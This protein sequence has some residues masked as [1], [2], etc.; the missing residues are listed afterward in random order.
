MVDLGRLWRTSLAVG[1]AGISESLIS[2]YEP[3][4]D[5]QGREGREEMHQRLCRRSERSSAGTLANARA[6]STYAASTFEATAATQAM[7]E[8][9]NLLALGRKQIQQQDAAGRAYWRQFD[10]QLAQRRK[11]AEAINEASGGSGGSAAGPTKA[12]KK[13]EEQLARFTQR[14]RDLTDERIAALERE[15]VLWGDL[16]AEVSGAFGTSLGDAIQAYNRHLEAI[17]DSMTHS[18]GHRKRGQRRRGRGCRGEGG[19]RRSGG[20]RHRLAEALNTHGR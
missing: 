12:L 7:Q 5:L 19:P 16:E 14:Y 20:L 9:S 17:E 10:E 2:A 6:A 15:V 11:A 3:L 8:A 4:R 18:P 13:Y 1:T